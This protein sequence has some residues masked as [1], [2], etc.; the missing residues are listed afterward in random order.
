MPVRMLFCETPRLIVRPAELKDYDVFVR[1]YE[2]CL[3]SQSRFDEGRFDT[4]FMTPEW[5]R[6][7]LES[8][9]ME[10]ESDASYTL[11]I[12]RKKDGASIGYCDIM[13]LQRGD[14]QYARIGYAIHN[15]CWRHGYATEAIEAI[16]KIAFESLNLHRIEAHIN[17]DNEVSKHVVLKAGFSFECIRKGFIL[18]DGVWTDNEIYFMN[19]ENWKTP[20]PAASEMD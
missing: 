11:S 13:P 19:N 14:F 3:P 4:D 7:W 2:C 20:E 8:R 18:E 5:Y 15:N 12:F 9:R 16:R 10:A 17:L 1:G 6:K